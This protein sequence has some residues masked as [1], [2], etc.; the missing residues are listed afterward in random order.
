MLKL[1]SKWQINL[2][3]VFILFL[4][5]GYLQCLFLSL[6]LQYGF[7][8]DDWRL[9]F[10]YKTLGNDPFSKIPYVW[11]I[12]GA[13]T[14]SQVYFIGLLNSFFGL[15]YQ[16]Y[17]VTN[18]IIK[19][20]ATISIYPL[21]LIIFRRKLLAFITT[22]LYGMSYMGSRSLEYVVK[23][24]D[25]LA[26]IPMNIFF[27]I[28]YFIVTG[29]VKRWWWFVL[30]TFFWF[31]SL[32]ISPIRI[33][34][35]LALIP[36]IEFFLCI[37]L[38]ST[39]QVLSSFKRLLILY[40]PLFFIYFY[41]Q[42][43]IIGFLQS[44]SMIFQAILRGN[45]H[46]ILT[47]FQGLGLIWFFSV[48]WNKFF[49]TIDVSS[50]KNYLFFLFGPPRGPLFIFG[51]LTLF[52]SLIIFGR[53]LYSFIVIL[54]SNL[55]LDIIFYYIVM[56][57]LGI[58]EIFKYRFDLNKMYPILISGFVLCI[59]LTSFLEW[60][61]FGKKNKLLFALWVTPPVVF[62]YIFLIWLLAPFGVGFENRQGYYL[63]IPAMAASLFISAFLV[64]IYDK[65]SDQKNRLFRLILLSV[66]FVISF[67]TFSL[68][69]KNID[70]YFSNAREDGRFAQ[71]QEGINNHLL[72]YFHS[73][74]YKE[75]NLFYFDGIEDNTHSN[76]YYEQALFESLP[77]RILLRNGKLEEGCVTTFYQGIDKLSKITTYDNGIKGFV[78]NGQCSKNVNGNVGKVFYPV[79]NFYA[80]RIKN[81]EIISIKQEILDKLTF[82]LRLNK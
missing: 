79:D 14:T 45:L 56:Y 57:G 75:N 65:A 60:R 41:K 40:L 47:P 39:R 62:L 68:N 27:I 6:V 8:P 3:L 23:G 78:Y 36:V 61:T 81:G 19:V 31:L 44:P 64:A 49:S 54:F 29:K 38:K 72:Q 33:Y 11:S 12:K 21:I 20:I 25:Y 77:S 10:F 34:P 7:T 15:N 55:L 22:I 48:E 42:D 74:N 1:A 69:R 58:P 66:I 13:Y 51:I 16:S 76:Y 63:I 24:T 53:K 59:A 32:V 2:L 73:F 82:S 43:A 5:V 46:I 37:Q 28:Y 9:L 71:D 70:Y 67:N 52:L 30:M 17:Q 35:I 50:F 80:F 4:I 18:L 26:I